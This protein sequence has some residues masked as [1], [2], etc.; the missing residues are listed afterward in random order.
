MKTPTLEIDKV[1]NP[2]GLNNHQKTE[3]HTIAQL[4][5]HVIKGEFT[6][7]GIDDGKEYTKVS[8]VKDAMELIFNLDEC[9]IIVAANKSNSSRHYIS[10][11]LGNNEPC[12]M[13]TDWSFHENDHDGF[14]KTMDKFLERYD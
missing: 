11:V 1:L 12:D 5:N 13:I 9:S 6:I 14:N 3:R 7:C 4:L 2:E 10:I 8:T